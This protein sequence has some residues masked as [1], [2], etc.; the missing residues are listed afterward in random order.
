MADEAV[1]AIAAEGG[2]RAAG[3]VAVALSSGAVA[4]AAAVVAVDVEGAWEQAGGEARAAGGCSGWC[5]KWWIRSRPRW[6]WCWW[7]TR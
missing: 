3:S 4:V 6:P 1:A 2:G 5:E 7:W